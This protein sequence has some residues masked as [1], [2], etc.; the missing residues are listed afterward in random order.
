MPRALF[1][2][3]AGPDTGK[4]FALEM[5]GTVRIGRSAEA[6]VVLK[7]PSVSRFH[8]EIA[9]SEAA[10]VLR[11]LGSR[12]GVFRGE[13]RVEE[14]RLKNGDWFVAG[15]TV[16][17]VRLESD[18][19]LPAIPGYVLEAEIG[20]GG[21]GSVYRAREE[22]TGRTVALKVLH[23]RAAA[24]PEA[25]ARFRR[26]ART[27]GLLR[28]PNI[29][30]IYDVGALGT[31]R[32]IEMEYVRGTDA[33]SRLRKEGPLPP[34]D[35][36]AI[37]VQVASVLVEAERKSIVHRDLKPANFLIDE[38]GRV[39]LCDFGIAKELDR[40]GLRPLTKDGAAPGTIAYMAPEQFTDPDGVGPKTDQYA[41]GAS[42]YHL[43]TG[44]PRLACS[45]Q[46]AWLQRIAREEVEPVSRTVPGA[47]GKLSTAIA[48]ML[49][50]DP[51]RRFPHA[52][53]TRAALEAAKGDLEGQLHA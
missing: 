21:M 18:P 27:A 25:A 34:P 36:A 49:K 14:T 20:S 30:E 3:S 41:L 4:R 33:L 40:L 28:H 48:T 11:D 8:A 38:Q 19:S 12:H 46:S 2:V 16:V 42:L 5:G 39:K 1:T 53:A 43:L 50:T 29:V 23:G 35:V 10:L 44:S 22:T 32:Y 9:F 45:S 17:Q 31:L 37:G 6:D 26:E 51:S 52:E 7:D 47:G 24:K 15:D 13:R